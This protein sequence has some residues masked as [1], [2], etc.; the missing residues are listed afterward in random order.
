[1]AAV[2][3]LYAVPD[4]AVLAA[5]IA[6]HPANSERLRLMP[7]AVCRSCGAEIM[8]VPTAA[9]KRLPLN[10]EP[11]PLGNVVLRRRENRTVFAHVLKKNEEDLFAERR[12]MPHHATCPSVDQHRR[13]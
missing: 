1:M 10:A 5:A 13:K 2:T 8:W 9:G 3:H 6:R 7:N 12:W 11:D 4:E